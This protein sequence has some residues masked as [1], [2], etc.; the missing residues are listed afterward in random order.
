MLTVF[1]VLAG[2]VVWSAL[3]RQ[4][5]LDP[6]DFSP[7]QLELM[8]L[9]GDVI[10]DPGTGAY[11]Y[12]PAKRQ[13]FPGPGDVWNKT[14]EEAR[15]AFERKGTNDHG[16]AWL[17]GYTL[18]RFFTGFGAASIVAIFVGVLIGLSPLL[19]KTLNPIIQFLKPISP[20][21]WLP[22]LL[23]SVKDPFWTAILVVFMASLWPTVANTAFG[24][25]NL[26]K[27]YLR[28]ADMLEMNFARRLFCVILPG[29][30]PTIIAGLRISFGSA[31]V[32]VV[33]AE[34]LLGELGVGY[35]SWIEWNNLDVAG[36][37][38]AIGVVGVVGVLLDF[39][40]SRLA[41]CFTY[42]E[43]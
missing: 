11:A 9:N 18:R 28:V 29:A 22:L 15:E 30:A 43:G 32:A 4:P 19:Y 33:P 8:E 42:S 38:F 5:R 10:R 6:A 17:V 35:L 37:I 31:L 12:N 23:Y 40:F 20:L 36:V 14:R 7:D 3:T 25:T 16:I 34:M 1:V 26:R 21:A 27:D 13:G 39:A 2:L 41:S 24:V